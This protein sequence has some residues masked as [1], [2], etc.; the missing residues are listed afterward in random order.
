MNKLA[1]LNEYAIHQWIDD[2]SFQRGENYYRH[3]Y[4]LNPRIQG[5]LLK[6]E[7]LGSQA[8][9]YRVEVTLDAERIVTSHC[10]CPVGSGH[11]KHVAA[12]L[13]TWVHNSSSFTTKETLEDMLQR[14][15][16]DMLITLVYQLLERAPELEG[17]LE[18]RVLSNAETTPA[19]ATETIRRQV[20]QAFYSGG[21]EWDAG[22]TIAM[23]LVPILKI[24]DERLAKNDLRN[25]LTVYATVARAILDDYE[26]IHDENGDVA[27]V[28]DDCATGLGQCLA[29]ATGQ[30]RREEILAELFHIYSWDLRYGGIGIG[31]G[32]PGILDQASPAERK[33]VASWAESALDASS[34]W[35]QQSYGRFILQLI[36][37]QLDDQE[38]LRLCRES[39]LF[40]ELVGR[41][42][43]LGRVE[44]A[45]AA[46]KEASDYELLQLVDIFVSHKH[47]ELARQLVQARIPESQDRRLSHWLQKYAESHNDPETALALAEELFWERPNLTQ[48][49]E[50]QNI[51]KSLDNWP[52]LHETILTRL[53]QEGKTNLLIQI[54]LEEGDVG[55]ALLTLGSR[56]A[57]RQAERYYAY[58][59][60]MRLQV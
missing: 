15:D 50:L 60:S 53:S 29:V 8:R 41:L 36:P 16:R 43:S 14:L 7:C 52:A 4:I 33:L 44:E 17:L 24:G 23:N 48:Y 9:S 46:T 54:H 6:A 31:D 12:L 37:D 39:A 21:D 55:S 42:L 18:L 1:Q 11:C 19:I 59:P 27:M 20:T 56:A 47:D 22:Y 58:G 28:V 35:S 32:I 5:Q 26:T 34:S 13:L 10:S 40:A 2:R 49:Q 51:A 57:S 30:V 45:A 25:A 38:F 3:G